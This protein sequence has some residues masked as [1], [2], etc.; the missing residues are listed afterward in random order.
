MRAPHRSA[1]GL[2]AVLSLAACTK[3]GGN[4]DTTCVDSAGCRSDALCVQAR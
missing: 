3:D 2:L 1:L 4:V